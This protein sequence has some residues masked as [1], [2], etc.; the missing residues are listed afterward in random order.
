MEGNIPLEEPARTIAAITRQPG[1]QRFQD[2]AEQ[3][4]FLIP[5]CKGCGRHHW[6]PRL[7]CPFCFSDDI[8]WQSATG[9][10]TV[11]SWTVMRRAKPAYAIAYVR[12]D[13]GPVVMTN[14]VGCDLDSIS[15]GMRVR[16]VFQ[17]ASNG[18]L[19]PMFKP[20]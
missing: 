18:P 19:V 10:G 13:E 4:V 16:A 9:N 6:Y 15:I 8:D 3:G 17:P 20:A 7:L 5:R 11:Y 1:M 14:I 2:A 12:M